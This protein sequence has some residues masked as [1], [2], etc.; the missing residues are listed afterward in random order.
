MRRGCI[1]KKRS[2]GKT[3]EPRDLWY[4]V[5]S[6][7]KDAQGKR[8]QKWHGSYETRETAEYFREYFLKQIEYGSYPLDEKFTLDRW[9]EERWFPMKRLQ[10]KESTY[11][12][13]RANVR[14]H[15]SPYLGHIPLH[16]LSTSRVDQHYR[17]LLEFG[18]LGK[19]NGGRLSPTTVSYVALIL[20]SAMQMAVDCEVIARNPVFLEHKP[21]PRSRVELQLVCWTAQELK[22]FLDATKDHRLATMWLLFVVSGMRRGEVLGLRWRDCDFTNNRISISN[23]IIQVDGAVLASTPKSNRARVVD[24]DPTSMAQLQRHRYRQFAEKARFGKEYADT[25]LVFSQ[26]NGMPLIPDHITREFRSIQRTLDNPTIRLHDLR[27]T[28]ASLTLAEGVSMKVVQERLGHASAETTA[29]LYAHV[30][31]GM[32]EEAAQ[33]FSGLIR[34]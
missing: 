19:H 31:P 1:V 7:G 25:D 15:I 24:I 28:H 34:S 30:L 8:R 21:R 20:F 13:Y 6:V 17:D 3:S 27:H 33:I 11:S 9:I 26:E 12:S 14:N 29:Q 32:Q 23:T 5:L 22:I 16:E 2:S 4:V 18:G 10:I